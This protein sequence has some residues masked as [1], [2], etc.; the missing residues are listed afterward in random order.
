MACYTAGHSLKKEE[1]ECWDP[2]SSEMGRIKVFSSLL[3]RE[4]K[5]KN[6]VL[7]RDHGLAGDW[8]KHQRKMFTCRGK[9][10]KNYQ[11]GEISMP[12]MALL[13]STAKR[14]CGDN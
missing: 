2:G 13:N 14:K 3:T 8:P 6:E 4:L 5:D 1:Q 10:Q 9:S 12:K 7:S 11:L